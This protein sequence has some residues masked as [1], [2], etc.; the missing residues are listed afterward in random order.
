M[1]SIA[2]HQGTAGNYDAAHLVVMERV[3]EHHR[4]RAF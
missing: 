2:R 1:L 4:E 3:E